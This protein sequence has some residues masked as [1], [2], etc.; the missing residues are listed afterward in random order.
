V[1]VYPRRPALQASARRLIIDWS[2]VQVLPSPPMPTE[3][4]QQSI[5]ISPLTSS[6]SKTGSYLHCMT[7]QSAFLLNLRRGCADP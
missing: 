1:A 4:E 3:A 2:S 5:C 6:L 7:D